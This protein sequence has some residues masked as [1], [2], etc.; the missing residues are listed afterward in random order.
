MCEEGGWVRRWVWM[1][2]V[3]W[4]KPRGISTFHPYLAGILLS[5]RIGRWYLFWCFTCFRY[6]IVTVTPN[7]KIPGQRNCDI[8]LPRRTNVDNVVIRAL[9]KREMKRKRERDGRSSERGML[10]NG[11]TATISSPFTWN[12][13]PPL[14]NMTC[15]PVKL[16]KGHQEHNCSTTLLSSG[17][18]QKAWLI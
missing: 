5:T 15:Q 18:A 16:G 8:S 17:C 12:L 4:L 7:R 6:T 3:R 13:V 14:M 11:T 2:G 10:V 9:R 1:C